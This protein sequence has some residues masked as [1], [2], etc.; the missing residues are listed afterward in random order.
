MVNFFCNVKPIITSFLCRHTGHLENFHSATLAFT[1][2]R[3]FFGSVCKT[4]LRFNLFHHCCQLFV[5]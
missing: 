5:A 4:Q 3:V 1:P 2:K